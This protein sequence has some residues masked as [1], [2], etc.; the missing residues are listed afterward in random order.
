MTPYYVLKALHLIFVITWFAGLFYIVRLFIY[1]V[2]TNSLEMQ[3]QFK[4]ME[5]RLWYGITW[6]SAVATIILGPIL[7]FGYYGTLTRLPLWLIIKLGLVA[8]LFLYHLSC[9]N[10]LKQLKNNQVN[11]TS[12]QLRIWNEVPTLF[13]FLI[14]FLTVFK[15][16]VGLAWGLGLTLGLIILTLLLLRLIKAFRS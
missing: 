8:L 7:M 15:M 9:G 10:I 6:P 3:E 13:L 5:R 4:I 2:E 11:Y 1:H 14:V 12:K 16:P